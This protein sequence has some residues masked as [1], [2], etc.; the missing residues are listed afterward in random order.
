[1]GLVFQGPLEGCLT[2]R[3]DVSS[4][5]RM[6]L[7]TALVLLT[8]AS[9]ATRA[10]AQ[11]VPVAP[12]LVAWPG[13]NTAATQRQSPALRQASAPSSQPDDLGGPLLGAAIGA[14]GGMLLVSSLSR[15]DRESCAWEGLENGVYIGWPL[16]AALGAHVGN[17]RRG[18]LFWDVFGTALASAVGREL[19]RR[20]SDRSWMVLYS[21]LGQI[22][23]AA[24]VERS[25]GANHPPRDTL[26]VRPGTSR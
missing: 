5:N 17:A 11:R 13:V 16:G 23:V 4:M 18:S 8:V 20:S 25:T 3:R 14:M 22:V 21:A 2:G 24:A 9:L 19:A 1:M 26:T 12:P 7:L 15:C 10:L 6:R